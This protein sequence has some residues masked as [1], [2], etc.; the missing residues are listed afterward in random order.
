MVLGYQRTLQAP[1]LYKLDISREAGTLAEKLEAAWSQRVSLAAE[2][3]AKL[4]SGEICPSTLKR[5]IWDVR[6][7]KPSRGQTYKERRA[8]ME[9][10]W[11]KVEGRKKASL[12]WALHDVFCWQFWLAGIFRVR[13]FFLCDTLLKY[14]IQT[15][16]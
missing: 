8:A 2:W 10:H 5:W 9:M 16:R 12:A 4:D 13:A 11:R 1:D 3:N 15:D 7:I 6:A 14:A